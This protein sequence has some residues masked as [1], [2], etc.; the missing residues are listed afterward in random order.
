MI[1]RPEETRDHDQIYA[2]NAA[3]FG[4]EA[5]PKLIGNLRGVDGFISLIAVEGDTVIAHISFSPVT[6][7]DEPTSFAGLAPMSVLPDRQSQGIGSSLVNA[8]LEACRIAGHSAIFVLGHPNYY[9]RFGF[10]TAADLGFTCEYPVSPEHFMVLEIETGS[11]AGRSGLI[12][13]HP[14]FAGT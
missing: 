7:N 11:L 2:L 8:G 9:P 3:A 5:E 10:Q 4:G 1:I 12:K 6:L 14:T 13:Y